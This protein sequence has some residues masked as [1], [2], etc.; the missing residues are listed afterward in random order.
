MSKLFSLKEWL[1]LPDASR[2]LAIV[3]GGDVT[4]ADVLRLG[5]DGQLRIS[6][7]FVNHAKALR[8]KIVA[9]SDADYEDVPSPDGSA[10]VRL[11]KGPVLFTGGMESDVLELEDEVLTLNGVFDLPMIGNEQLDIEHR[12][13]Y[14]TGGPAVTRGGLDGTFVRGKDGVV[15]QLQDHFDDDHFLPGSRAQLAELRARGRSAN[16]DKSKVKELLDRY[17]EDRENLLKKKSS[18]T[19]LESYYPAGTLP[20]DSVQVVRTESLRQFEQSLNDAGTG[21]DAPMSTNERTTLLI[22]IATLCDYSDTK[23]ERGVA[24]KIAKMTEEIGAAITDD[25]IRKVLEKIPDALER[26]QK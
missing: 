9:I 4:E 8:G 2:H 5:L 1:T 10:T 7:Y 26:R 6:V 24:G 23:L 21:V 22:I 20:K 17:Q 19:E 16:I 15:Y 25:T 11:Y 18:Q 3:F 14:L 12:Y 13:H